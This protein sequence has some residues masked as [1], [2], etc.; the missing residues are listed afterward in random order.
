MAVLIIIIIF[1]SPTPPSRYVALIVGRAEYMSRITTL[2]YV[3]FIVILELWRGFIMLSNFRTYEFTRPRRKH[4]ELFIP[5]SNNCRDATNS[6]ERTRKLNV[7]LMKNDTQARRVNVSWARFLCCKLI[8]MLSSCML[9][10]LIKSSFFVPDVLISTISC[11]LGHKMALTGLI[12]SVTL[13]R[14]KRIEANFPQCLMRLFVETFRLIYLIDSKLDL[15]YGLL[16]HRVV[17]SF[18]PPIQ[19]C[20]LHFDRRKKKCRNDNWQLLWRRWVGKKRA[21]LINYI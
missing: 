8:S 4:K 6:V 5:S 17:K 16:N 14:I 20:G 18:F 2:M 21:G 19:H 12:F 1:S 9:I 15:F 10:Q 7:M 3:I 11:G 13:L